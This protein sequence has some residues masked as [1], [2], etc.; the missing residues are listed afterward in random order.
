MQKEQSGIGKVVSAIG[1]AVAALGAAALASYFLADAY[2]RSQG[3][4]MPIEYDEE[5]AQAE[6]PTPPEEEE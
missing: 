1:I 6:L 4:T 3:V 5:D 2:E